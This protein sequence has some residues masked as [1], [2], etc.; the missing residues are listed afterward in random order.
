MTID[1]GDLQNLKEFGLLR[2]ANIAICVVAILCLLFM[3]AFAWLS[4]PL[5]LVI[6]LQLFL[7]A[8]FLAFEIGKSGS[9][10]RHTVVLALIV[11]TIGAG[12]F[13]TA[14]LISS[15]V[16]RHRPKQSDLTHPQMETGSL[17]AARLNFIRLN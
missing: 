10:A 3:F 7:F 12:Y 14:G 13:Y 1:E 8:A 17:S 15:L 9:L 16:P 4:F 5:T 11:A 6:A 2:A